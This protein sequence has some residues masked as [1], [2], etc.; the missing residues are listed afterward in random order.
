MN[1]TLSIELT[2]ALD[3]AQS[4][5]AV[6]SRILRAQ[7][8]ALAEMRR[9][10][11]TEAKRD[12]GLEYNL[13]AGRI[14]QGLRTQNTPDGIK[15]VGK[16]RG[17]NAIEFGATWSRVRGAGLVSRVSRLKYAAPRALHLRGDSGLGAKWSARRGAAKTVH[18]GTFIARGKNG[19]MLVLQRDPEGSTYTPKTGWHA[20][21]RQTPRLLGVY[22][23]SV[24][25]MLKHGRRPER[26]A[27]FALGKVDEY[28]RKELGITP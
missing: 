14:S 5:S 17:I 13:R 12:I 1:P 4:M 27:E 19:A 15:L 7:E 10:L 18:P 3:A 8:H 2:G 11:G 20:G 21:Q 26:L 22:G 9:R 28:L 23:L 24:G 6:P 16:S 25:Q